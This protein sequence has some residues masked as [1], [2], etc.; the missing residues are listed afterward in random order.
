MRGPWQGQG[1]RAGRH[2]AGHGDGGGGPDL[3]PAQFPGGDGPADPVS[4]FAAHVSHSAVTGS[5]MAART[6]SVSYE[7]RRSL[8]LSLGEA[9]QATLRTAEGDLRAAARSSA[10]VLGRTA[11]LQVP[12]VG[13]GAVERGQVEPQG[14]GPGWPAV[15]S[16]EGRPCGG[17]LAGA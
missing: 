2:H 14:P 8:S 5:E 16:G 3:V 10:G 13:C 12:A 1:Q 7:P 6:F 17:S 4:R 15:R 9:T 11:E